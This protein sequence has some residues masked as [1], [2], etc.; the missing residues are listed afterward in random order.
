MLEEKEEEE[1]GFE[2]EIGIEMLSCVCVCVCVC[3]WV[4]IGVKR[5][6]GMVD[7]GY[8]CRVCWRMGTATGTGK[9]PW[10]L[11]TPRWSKVKGP[12][13]YRLSLEKSIIQR[14]YSRGCVWVK[15]N[16]D[17]LLTIVTG[18]FLRYFLSSFL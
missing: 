10:L 12:Y 11:L 4:E 6:M 8:L 9:G 7:Y 17:D 15:V 14:K 16:T 3:V 2:I 1:K 18:G 5:G 13:F